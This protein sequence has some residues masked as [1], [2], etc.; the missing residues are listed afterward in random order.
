MKPKYL[1]LL[2]CALAVFYATVETSFFGSSF[3]PESPAEVIADGIATIICAIGLACMA[4]CGAIER[5]RKVNYDSPK[6]Q[7]N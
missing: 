3:W 7:T 2:I 4:I 6:N 5:E 1:G